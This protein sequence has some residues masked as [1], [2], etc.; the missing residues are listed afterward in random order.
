A[1]GDKAPMPT[2]YEVSRPPF[3]ADWRSINRDTG[4]TIDWD[5]VGEEYRS[6]PGQTVTASAAAAAGATSL[7]VEALTYAVPSG[8]VMNF[9]TFAAVTVTT[10]G[11]ALAA[12]TSIPVDALSGPIPSAAVLNLTV[13]GY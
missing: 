10:S 2:T 9:G 3:V 1:G 8:T 7:P 12:A 4:A 6:T 5:N 13:A 11:A